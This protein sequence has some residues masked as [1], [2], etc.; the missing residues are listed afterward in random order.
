MEDT[1]QA[2]RTLA[3]ARGGK[4]S[5]TKLLDDA[6]ISILLEKPITLTVSD[7]KAL[8]VKNPVLRASL[9]SKPAHGFVLEAENVIQRWLDIVEEHD[10]A[11]DKTKRK[12]LYGS[13][14]VATAKQD[15]AWLRRLAVKQKKPSAGTSSKLPTPSPTARR[16]TSAVAKKPAEERRTTTQQ[17][18][19][20]QAPRSSTTARQQPKQPLKTKDTG[21]AIPRPRNPSGTKVQRTNQPDD[22]SAKSDDTPTENHDDNNANNSPSHSR[23]S[24]VVSLNTASEEHE[25][26]TQHTEEDAPDEPQLEADEAQPTAEQPPSP[27]VSEQDVEDAESEHDAEV[28]ATTNHTSNIPTEHSMLRTSLSP[29]SVSSLPRPETPEVEQLRQRFESL[30]QVGNTTASQRTGRSPETPISV[31]D[32]K[33]KS[34]GGARVKSMVNFFMDENLHKWEF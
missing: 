13:P 14:S 15:I 6:G 5:L 34:P 18:Q 28:A 2:Q 27:E 22:P 24:S 12:F 1:G 4:D 32:A 9:G 33:P 17:S 31:K 3:V 20:S 16:T 23:E 19:R 21:K 25:T 7:A 29:N 26:S 10:A 30:A 11:A 8:G